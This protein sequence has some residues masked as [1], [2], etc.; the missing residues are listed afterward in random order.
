MTGFKCVRNLSLRLRKKICDGYK[1][2]FNNFRSK[3][4]SC[5]ATWLFLPVTAGAPSVQI[6]PNLNQ[7]SLTFFF[8][9]ICHILNKFSQFFKQVWGS[10]VEQNGQRPSNSLNYSS[11]VVCFFFLFFLTHWTTT[12]NCAVSESLQLPSV[13]SKKNQNTYM[14]LLKIESML[15]YHLLSSQPLIVMLHEELFWCISCALLFWSGLHSSN[16]YTPLP[17][18]C[19]PQE[20]FFLISNRDICCYTFAADFSSR[21]RIYFFPD[22]KLLYLVPFS[23]WNQTAHWIQS[24][25]F[26]CI[27]FSVS[28]CENTVHI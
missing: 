4:F 15:L 13:E 14:N 19:A 8:P 6:L 25:F 16:W 27:N 28:L 5:K 17:S 1:W 3:N 26:F 10:S 7:S 11:C 21:M 23:L 24:N 2:Y 20:W 12:V 22:K 18:A 9:T